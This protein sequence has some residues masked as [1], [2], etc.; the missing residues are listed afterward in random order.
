MDWAELKLKQFFLGETMHS[1][2]SNIQ[3]ELRVLI[4]NHLD[5]HQNSDCY[6]DQGF[7]ICREIV[8]FLEWDASEIIVPS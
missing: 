5:S 4:P 7:W 8:I 2:T 6:Y 3:T 1:L